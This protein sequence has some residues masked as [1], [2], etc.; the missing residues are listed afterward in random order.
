MAASLAVAKTLRAAAVV[1]ALAGGGSNPHGWIR[2]LSSEA[3]VVSQS[4][5]SA[6][7]VGDY[8]STGCM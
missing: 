7:V 8:G 4:E 5:G 3:G 6:G 2:V 1:C